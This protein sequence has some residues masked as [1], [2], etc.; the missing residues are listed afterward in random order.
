MADKLR[1]RLDWIS[2]RRAWYYAR[3]LWP[4]LKPQW[5]QIVLMI[6][7]MLLYGAGY[8]MRIAVIKPFFELVADPNAEITSDMREVMQRFGPYAAL[9]FG[10]AVLMAIGTFLKHYYEGWVKAS[11]VINLQREVVSR[12][13]TQP[14]AFFNK[15]RKGA[16]M[17]RI[18]GN[19]RAAGQLVQI[20]LD[21]FLAHPITIIAVLAVLLFTSPM[22]T[23]LTF[24]VFPVVLL[25]VVMF[26]GKIR[27][28]THKKYQKGEAS[29]QF[30]HQLLDGI[31]VVKSYRLEDA[32]RE[33]FKRVSEK[34]FYHDRKVSRYKGSSRFGVELS[35]NTLMAAA[36]LGAGMVMT[37]VWF[38]EMGGLA[39]FAQYFAGLIFLYDP[40]RKIGHTLN[41]VQEST[42]GL[43]RVF[44]LMD[45]QPELRDKDGAVEAPTTFETIEFDHL[46]FQYMKDRPVL[47]DITFKVKRGQMIAFVGG[48]GM[49]KSTLMDLIPRFYDPTAGAIKVDGV[50]MREFKAES[51]LRNI[52]IVSQDTFLFNATVR[53]NIMVGRPEATEE[54]V[55]KA[56]QAAHIWAEIQAMPK[57]LDSKLGERGVSIS[58]G[59]RQRIAIARAFLRRSPILLLDEATSS[60]DTQSEREVQ[61]ALDELIH[62]CTVFA[63]AHR[64]STIRG[65]DVILVLNEGRIIERGNHE[66]LMQL[67]GAYASAY[68][69][70]HG[71]NATAEA[72]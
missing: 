34:L 41:G 47:R 67:N 43:D 54:D 2:L 27:R 69:L 52:A 11:T 56:A 71:E 9:L 19:T 40:A 61:K 3:H 12:L 70:Q 29:G 14:M 1:N 20:L 36:L 26:A 58:G 72:A 62:E 15:E 6:A 5:F 17:S 44:E 59:Q 33:E 37:T 63:V 31:R 57:G 65:A 53:E 25:P 16:L 18:G 49:G 30:F 45:R 10:G 60:L 7:G 23:L 42:A 32:Q 51:W 22:L 21:A 64:L 48:S 8:G 55:I 68:R 39:L 66:E 13:L 28:A 50:D 38:Q 35:Y 24:I 4:Y 46:E